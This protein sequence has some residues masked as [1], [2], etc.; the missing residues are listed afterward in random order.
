MA[1]DACSRG[2]VTCCDSSSVR[3]EGEHAFVTRPILETAFLKF[4][5]RLLQ[6]LLRIHHDWPIAK[7]TDSRFTERII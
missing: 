5:K 6:L 1:T 2:V 4:L 3:A 7:E